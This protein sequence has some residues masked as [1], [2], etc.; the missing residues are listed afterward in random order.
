MELLG[1]F[2][3]VEIGM[4]ENKEKEFREKALRKKDR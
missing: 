1:L 2:H 4:K 3:E